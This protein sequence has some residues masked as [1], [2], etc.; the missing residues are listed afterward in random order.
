MNY[1]VIP[2]GLAGDTHGR[3][4]PA[5]SFVYRQVLDYFLSIC[6]T[7]DTVYLAPANT[8]D[9][10]TEHQLAFQ[11]LISK[12]AD[13]CISFPALIYEKYVDTRGNARHLK[14]FLGKAYRQLSFDLVCAVLHSYRAEYCFK[15]EG[16]RL[17]KI[18]RVPYKVTGEGIASRWWYY[19]Y[20]PLHFVYETLAFCRDLFIGFLAKLQTR[21]VAVP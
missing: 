12:N 18:H 16:Y 4:L 6:R 17:G 9:G 15:N 8:Y 7:G 11:Y 5:P 2:E 14:A 20:R 10:K 21:K 19:R 3:P 1:I 13:C